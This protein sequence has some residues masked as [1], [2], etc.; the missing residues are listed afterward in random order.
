MKQKVNLHAPV[1]F[2]DIKNYRINDTD[3]YIAYD[4]QEFSINK[5]FIEA[6]NGF[7]N[8][9]WVSGIKNSEQSV[10]INLLV[11]KTILEKHNLEYPK[12]LLFGIH[13]RFRVLQ[14]KFKEKPYYDHQHN[15]FSILTSDSNTPIFY[16]QWWAMNLYIAS[17]EWEIYHSYEKDS[18]Y[19]DYTK[20][21]AA[22]QWRKKIFDAT[23]PLLNR[24]HTP[25]FYF[26]KGTFDKQIGTLF[27]RENKI[28]R[29]WLTKILYPA[30][31]DS[32]LNIIN[33]ALQKPEYIEEKQS[34]KH[35]EGPNIVSLEN[36]FRLLTNRLDLELKNIWSHLNY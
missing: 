14:E 22:C 18:K 32:Y 4:T 3:L 23:Q 29:T 28:N 7:I 16:N 15:Y 12:R 27:F 5:P 36:T 26:E 24:G 1:N 2:T 19:C 34:V 21:L 25:Y 9:K 13:G 10:K 8:D 31:H 35:I 20:K 11:F 6:W 30:K 17:S 33:P